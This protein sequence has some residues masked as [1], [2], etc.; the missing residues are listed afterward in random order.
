VVYAESDLPVQLEDAQFHGWPFGI[1]TD[2]GTDPAAWSGQP[3]EIP[4]GCG[5][6]ELGQRAGPP[7]VAWFAVGERVAELGPDRDE[8]QRTRPDRPRRLGSSGG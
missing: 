3:S 2:G 7:T 4:N 6:E 5:H 1:P 8:Y